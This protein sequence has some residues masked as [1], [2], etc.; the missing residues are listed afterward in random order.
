MWATD[1]TAWAVGFVCS[2]DHSWKMSG[3][4]ETKMWV[5]AGKPDSKVDIVVWKADWK[6]GVDVM[7]AIVPVHTSF[8]PMRIVTY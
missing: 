8:A 5:P 6:A 4:D 7:D 1:Q 2:T 3:M